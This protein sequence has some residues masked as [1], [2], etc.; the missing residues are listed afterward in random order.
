MNKTGNVLFLQLIRRLSSFNNNRSK[1]GIASLIQNDDFNIWSEK[2]WSEIGK[3]FNKS[4]DFPL[5]GQIGT[6][7]EL[8]QTN[9]TNKKTNL[10]IVNENLQYLFTKPLPQENQFIKL[11]EAASAIF[12]EEKMDTLFTSE[13]LNKLMPNFEMKAY[14]CPKS[15]VL[16]NNYH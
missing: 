8:D 6:V 1:I 4:Q 16:G 11:K 7:V 5:P 13:D 10:N 15:L 14:Q 12:Y 9:T 3:Q 2:Y